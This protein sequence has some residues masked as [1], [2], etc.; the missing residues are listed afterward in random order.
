MVERRDHVLMIS[1][2][3][4][5]RDFSAFFIRKPSTNGPFHTERAKLRPPLLVALPPQD[6][7]VGRLVVTRLVAFGALAPGRHRM[8]IAAGAAAERVIDGVHRLTA[9]IAEP[10]KPAR[11]PRFADEDV[12]LIGVG[13]R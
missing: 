11:T 10:A 7:A 4:E 9:H 3:P 5:A 13:H 8:T 12:L 1:L 2:R 6:V